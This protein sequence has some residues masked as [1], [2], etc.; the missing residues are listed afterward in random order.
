MKTNNE[1][2]CAYLVTLTHLFAQDEKVQNSE[3][4]IKMA[5]RNILME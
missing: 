2:F 4:D 1:Y 5:Q 3:N